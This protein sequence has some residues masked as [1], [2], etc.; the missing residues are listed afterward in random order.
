MHTLIVLKLTITNGNCAGPVE[1]PVGRKEGRKT[2]EIPTQV[3]EGA[4]SARE[5]R[6]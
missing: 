2:R 1:F 4:R 3:G 5:V 6:K